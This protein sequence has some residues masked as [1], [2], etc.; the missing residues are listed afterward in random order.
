MTSNNLIS[1]LR[2]N[3]TFVWILRIPVC[4]FLKIC[5]F[6]PLYFSLYRCPPLC[7]SSYI[8]LSVYVSV[9]LVE[10]VLLSSL[11][12]QKSAS[13]ERFPTA[14]PP[15][16]LSLDRQTSMQEGRPIDRYT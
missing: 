8:C 6:P 3:S 12:S 4:I 13:E 9:F 14:R 16:E 10:C 1:T 5:L 7:S 2:Q 15:S 11:S